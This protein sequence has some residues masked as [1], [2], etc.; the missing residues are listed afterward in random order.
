MAE[1]PDLYEVSIRF[2]ALHFSRAALTLNLLVRAGSG[3]ITG[4]GEISRSLSPPTPP[5]HI[6][7][8]TGHVEPGQSEDVLHVHVSGEYVES[9]KPPAIGSISGPFS[10]SCVVDRQWGGQG[11]FSYGRYNVGRCVVTNI[12]E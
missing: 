9:L 6:F 5:A 4:S 10:A 12:G 2:D 1:L 3:E 11:T 7:Q 8:L